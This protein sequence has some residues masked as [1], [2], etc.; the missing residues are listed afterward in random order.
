MARHD[1]ATNLHRVAHQH[2]GARGVAVAR[3]ARERRRAVAHALVALRP[4]QRERDVEQRDARRVVAFA[5]AVELAERRATAVTSS[6]VVVGRDQPMILTTWRGVVC[7]A[8]YS[9]VHVC[10]R[11]V[12]R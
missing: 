8:D 11:E 12:G 3:D 4:A 9:S 6:F 5:R 1:A 10:L 7:P 2:L